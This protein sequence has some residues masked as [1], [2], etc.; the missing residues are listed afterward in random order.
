[1]LSNCREW[2]TLAATENDILGYTTEML[3]FLL[4]YRDIWIDI[5]NVLQR[6]YKVEIVVVVALNVKNK[7]LGQGSY[8]LRLQLKGERV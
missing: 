4:G 3:V 5:E 2:T 8:P 1:M 7:L 6:E